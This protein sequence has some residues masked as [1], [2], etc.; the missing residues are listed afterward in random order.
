MSY[1]LIKGDFH[2]HYPAT[3]RQGPEPDGDTL[4]FQPD[5]RQLVNALPRS[6]R[7]A[8]FTRNGM[9]SIRFEGIDALETHFAVAGEQF[10]QHEQLALAARDQ[11]LAFAGFGAVEYFADKPFKVKSVEHHPRRGYILSNGLDTF[12]R[13]VAFAFIGDH[14]SSDGTSIFV[15][16]DMLDSS[17]NAMMLDAGQ[18]YGAFYLSLPADLRDS[19]LD[20]VTAAR[21]AERGLWALATATTTESALINDAQT[22]ESLVIWPKLFRRLAA[23]YQEGFTSL[24]NFDAWLRADPVNRDDRL[25]LPN[26][27]LGNMHDM[28]VIDGNQLRLAYQPEDVVIVPDDFVLSEPSQP[29]A[30]PPVLP[31]DSTIDIRLIAALVNPAGTEAGNEVVTLLNAGNADVSLDG[32]LLADNNGQQRL[33]GMLNKGQ[34]VQLSLAS[35]VRLSNQR[36]TITLLNAQQEIVDQV[37]YESTQLPPEGHTLVF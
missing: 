17:L 9:T 4:K 33:N 1:T 25:I 18:A 19:L 37:S 13:T 29:P 31:S 11:L 7:P 35:N 16:P 21:N 14:P 10:H 15:T 8:R 23:F 28:L 27:S 6:N 36:D 2:I 32:W 26:R 34:L 20:K 5:N 24:A 30:K 22:L 3:P 12:G